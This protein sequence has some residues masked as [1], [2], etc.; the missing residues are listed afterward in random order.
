MTSLFGFNIIPILELIGTGFALVSVWLTTRQNIWCWPVSIICPLIYIFIFYE[1]KLYA[2]SGLQVFYVAVSFYGW[3]EWL[4]GKKDEEE[5]IEKH[6]VSGETGALYNGQSLR[7]S[8]AS[9]MMWLSTL[10]IGSII[11][12]GMALLL[13]RTDST[14]P[15]IDAGATAFSL[16]AT[17]MVARKVLE[18]WVYW[19]VIDA[20]YVG[21]SI[22]KGLYITGGQYFIFTVLAAYGYWEWKKEME[23]A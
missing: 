18:N 21:M 9:G 3:Y 19:I 11:T 17:W 8:K 2:D 6:L 20:V 15:W 13:Q 14:M 23:R 4:Y 5:G 16:V 10:V 22:Y 1:S 7:V 12:V